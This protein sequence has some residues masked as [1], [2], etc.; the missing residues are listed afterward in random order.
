MTSKLNDFLQE[1]QQKRQ[2]ITDLH[3]TIKDD[4]SKL[5]ELQTEYKEA[6][7]GDTDNVDDLFHEMESIESKIK[8]DKHKLETLTD[9]TKDDLRCKALEAVQDFPR[10][11]GEYTDKVH[12]IHKRMAKENERHKEAMQEL[13]IEGTS[14]N[15]EYISRARE[16]SAILERNEISVS[17]KLPSDFKYSS[18]DIV[19]RGKER[20]EA[21]EKEK[22]KAVK[23]NRIIDESLYREIESSADGRSDRMPFNR[24]EEH[25]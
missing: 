1:E 12:S 8:A 13:I 10:I 7:A 11:K 5:G 15:D 6:V 19:K 14:I 21:L 9:I 17:P 23:E 24:R 3:R 25:N 18:T 20:R 2:R 4:E 22:E 16:H